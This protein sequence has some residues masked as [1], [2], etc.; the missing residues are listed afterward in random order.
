MG[1][2]PGDPDTDGDGR[3]DGLEVTIG[4][5]PL[6]PDIFVAVTYSLMQLTGP[7]DGGDGLNDW[8]WRLSVQESSQRFPGTMLSD[9]Q[10]DCPPDGELHPAACM[11]NRYNFFLNKSTAVA[12]TPDNGIVL[13]G[14]IVEINSPDDDTESIDTVVPDKCRMSF[15]DQPLTYDTLQGGTFMT[16]T[17]GPLSDLNRDPACSATIVAEISVNCVGEGKHNCRA[18]NPC[19]ADED[20]ANDRCTA[21]TQDGQGNTVCDGVGACESKCGNGVAEAAFD[22]PANDGSGEA[23][24]N[25]ELCDDGNIDDCGTCNA[26]CGTAGAAGPKTCPQGTPCVDDRDCTGRC[27]FTRPPPDTVA[28]PATCKDGCGTC[29]PVCGNGVRE[30]GE[31]CD[32]RNANDCGD[33]NAT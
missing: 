12:L 29:Q 10:S 22:C 16:R 4:T 31:T 9:E 28:D 23:T 21:C 19:V 20:C 15:V 18:G 32:D 25:C 13:N 24:A 26:T 27:D 2:D 33:C 1:T 30:P 3:L 8:A 11:T 5:N 17:F 7:Q 6:Q 14:I